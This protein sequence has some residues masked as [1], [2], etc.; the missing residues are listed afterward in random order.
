MDIFLVRLFSRLLSYVPLVARKPTKYTGKNLKSSPTFRR[1]AAVPSANRES[2]WKTY[3]TAWPSKLSLINAHYGLFWEDLFS[4][5][6]HHF[7]SCPQVC[8]NLR[9]GGVDPN[10]R[11]QNTNQRKRKCLLWHGSI[12]AKEKRVG[13]I[14]F[15][16]STFNLAKF[17]F[18]VCTFTISDFTWIWCWATWTSL[19][20]ATRQSMLQVYTLN[21]AEPAVGVKTSSF[22]FL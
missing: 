6:G 16:T 5:K 11:S 7:I 18:V 1:H 17:N 21:W 10:R 12:F 14:F 4:H 22:L 2:V 19:S 3:D 9:R 15:P 20:S 13:A 8:A